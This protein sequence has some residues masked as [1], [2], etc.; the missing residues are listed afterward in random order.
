[1]RVCKY[2]RRYWAVFDDLEQLV[3]VAVYKK[4]AHEVKRR[5]EN[6]AELG[7][8]EKPAPFSFGVNESGSEEF[9]KEV[10]F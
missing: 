3:C 10:V 9:C 1:M 8:G 6:P 7:V 4:G 2:G 5:L